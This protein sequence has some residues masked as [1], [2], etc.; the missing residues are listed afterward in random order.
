MDFMEIVVYTS[1]G[2]DDEYEIRENIQ[3]DSTEES[4]E[5]LKLELFQGAY[6]MVVVQ[7]W[8]GNG[9][10]KKRVRQQ[11]FMRLVSVC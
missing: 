11:R 7:Y 3:T 5:Q 4:T 10:G 6:L 9:I 2:I 8:A 1:A